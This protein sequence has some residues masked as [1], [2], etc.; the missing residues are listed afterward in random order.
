M[1]SAPKLLIHTMRDVTV[2]NFEDSS[3]LDT[4]QVEAIGNQLYELVDVRCTKKLILDFSKVRF[5]SSSALGVL[6]NLRTKCNAIKGT[7][8]ICSLRADLMKVFEITNLKKLFTFC[9]GE[10]EALESFGILGVG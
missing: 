8:V 7:L 6:I 3:I 1:P 5:L 10:K 9:P 2:V 4:A